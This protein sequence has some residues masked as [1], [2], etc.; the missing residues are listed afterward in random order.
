MTWAYDYA[1]NLEHQHHDVEFLPNGNILILAW[2]TIINATAISAGRNPA[3]VGNTL[4]SEKIVE[5]EPIGTDSV[6]VV[7][8][9]HLWDHLIQDFDS[10]KKKKQNR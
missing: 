10:T 4:W 1:T 2:E 8:E 9:W 7:W 5:I 6:N 3:L